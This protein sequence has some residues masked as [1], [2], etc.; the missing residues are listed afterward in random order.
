MN[1][2]EQLLRGTGMARQVTVGEGWKPY[3]WNGIPDWD[4]AKLGPMPVAPRKGAQWTIEGARAARTAKVAAMRAEFERLREQGQSVEE[5]AA[6]AGVAVSTAERYERQ[7]TREA[8][9]T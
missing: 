6:A 8:G 5:A 1:R 2:D 7:R 9:A 4:P 3:R